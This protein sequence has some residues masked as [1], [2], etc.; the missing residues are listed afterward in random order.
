MA[1]CRAG[2]ECGQC[3]KVAVAPGS[4]GGV[5]KGGLLCEYFRL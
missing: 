1:G 2:P 3:M 4:L 5:I